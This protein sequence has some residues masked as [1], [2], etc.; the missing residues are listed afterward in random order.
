MEE[1][2]NLVNSEDKTIVIFD[3]D[4]GELTVRRWARVKKIKPTK[5]YSGK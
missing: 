5:I 4:F 2:L 3:E 1:A